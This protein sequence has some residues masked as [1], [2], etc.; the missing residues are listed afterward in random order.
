MEGSGL[1]CN[2]ICLEELN[3]IAYVRI[4]G[5]LLVFEPGTDGIRSS[6]GDQ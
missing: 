4:S 2:R 5:R 3:K 6:C 1:A